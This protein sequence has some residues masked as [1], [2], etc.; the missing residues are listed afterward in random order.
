MLRVQKIV[1]VQNEYVDNFNGF[2]FFSIS[3]LITVKGT[4][5]RIEKRVE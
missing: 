5:G 3:F 2:C 4:I 1:R